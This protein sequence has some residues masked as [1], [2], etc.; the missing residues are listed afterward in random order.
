MQKKNLIETEILLGVFSSVE[1][2]YVIICIKGL[3][4]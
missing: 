2:F 4:N 3:H 1:K